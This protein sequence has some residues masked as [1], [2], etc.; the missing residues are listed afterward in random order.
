MEQALQH[1]AGGS[2]KSGRQLRQQAGG[3]APQ[4][5]GLSGGVHRP[6]PL[7]AAAGFGL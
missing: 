2:A 6:D 1:H 4:A 3:G 7:R 5:L